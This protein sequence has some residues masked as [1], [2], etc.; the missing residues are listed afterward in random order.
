MAD[1]QII[2]DEGE[3]SRHQLA[4]R[5]YEDYAAVFDQVE[6]RI[7]A[8]AGLQGDALRVFT[9]TLFSRLMFLRFIEL[10]DWLTFQG[11]KNY[12]HALHAAGR[13]GEKS[14]YSGRLRP[15]FFEG[16]TI[17][18]RQ[19]SDAYGCVPYL[20]GGLF[21]RS[22]L[23]QRVADLPDDLF[24]DILG[25]EDATGLL[26]RYSF[27]VEES[28]PADVNRRT[29]K[30]NVKGSGPCFW[31]G[32]SREV[33]PLSPKNGP[34]PGLCSSPAD[35]KAAIDPE[36][37]GKVFEELVT[38]RHETG[39]YYTPRVVVA[40]MCREAI[41]AYL[42]GRRFSSPS[43]R[44][45]GGGEDQTIAA[46]EYSVLST[47]YSGGAAGEGI[48]LPPSGKGAAGEGTLLPPLSFRERGSGRGHPTPLSFRERGRG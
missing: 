43:G 36:M 15:L 2:E 25:A 18:G 3:R 32:I 28:K 22:D 30:S 37:L 26:Y 42:S 17:E 11:S 38:G 40:F 35:I 44:N 6:K 21:Q 7:A 19:Q 33:H 4:R 20:N 27:T 45:A 23:D 14:F 8:Q 24:A 48:L 9:Q 31:A 5:F 41:K 29:A 1:L 16:L 10:K 12:L 46:T 13:Y 47:Q 34:D 39:S